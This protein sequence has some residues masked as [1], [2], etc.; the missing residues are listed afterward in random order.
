LRTRVD[1]STPCPC[2]RSAGSAPWA[3]RWC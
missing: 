3:A 1:A 2:P